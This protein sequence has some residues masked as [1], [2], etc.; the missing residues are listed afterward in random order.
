MKRE[1]EKIAV[2]TV[3]EM[4]GVSLYRLRY[5]SFTPV[6]LTE[7]ISNNKELCYAKK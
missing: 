7:L 6:T 1:F 2:R 3:M 5:L 4:W